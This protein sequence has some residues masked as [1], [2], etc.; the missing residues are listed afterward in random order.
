[1]NPCV[2]LLVGSSV[3]WSVMI[4]LS[5]TSRKAKEGPGA[6]LCKRSIDAYIHM[7]V[8]KSNE[9]W[10]FWIEFTRVWR[11]WGVSWSVSLP[12]VQSISSSLVMS[13]NIETPR[14]HWVKFFK[15]SLLL[16]I[17]ISYLEKNL[18][19]TA[20]K[21]FS[22]PIKRFFLWYLVDFGNF[23]SFFANLQRF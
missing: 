23:T 20:T 15:V 19:M 11:G 6:V 22:L 3:Y 14:S 7:Y 18:K 10:T 2:R 21:K 17:C 5:S 4:P 8:H 12:S 13:S 9:L 16:D 1:M